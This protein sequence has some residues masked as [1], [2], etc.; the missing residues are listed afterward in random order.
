M[1]C[2]KRLLLWL[3]FGIC[4][5][6]LTGRSTAQGEKT[7]PNG[8][9]TL[10]DGDAK[11][12]KKAVADL[13]ARPKETLDF[14]KSRVPKL[15]PLPANKV[16]DLIRDMTDANFDIRSQAQYDLEMQQELVALDLRK[17]I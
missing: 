4:A 9:A 16:Q 10:A 14:V 17:V 2:A 15:K 13:V 8:W 7:T 6:I 11:K 12:A 1:Y 3:A 5:C